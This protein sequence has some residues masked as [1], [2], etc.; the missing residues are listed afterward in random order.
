MEN[1][2]RKIPFVAYGTMLV[3][4]LSHLTEMKKYSAG[5]TI[6]SQGQPADNMLFILSGETEVTSKDPDTGKTKIIA[7]RGPGE[8]VGE[9]ALIENTVRSARLLQ[10]R[11]LPLLK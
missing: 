2:T 8:M 4:L 5:E 9:L 1:I 6:F 11:I 10:S 3:R 7:V